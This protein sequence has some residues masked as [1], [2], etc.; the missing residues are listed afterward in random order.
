MAGPDRPTVRSGRHPPERVVVIGRAGSGKTT[1]ALALGKLFHIPVVYLDQLYWTSDWQPVSNDRYE[2]LHAAA[3]AAD[4]WILDGGYMTRP[5]FTYRV[6]RADL[7][8]ITEASLARCLV[9]VV[10]R[11]LW[12]RGRPRAGRPVGAEEHFSLTFL[13]WIFRWT[14]KHR[15]LAAEIRAL[16]PAARIVVVRRAQDLE[17]LLTP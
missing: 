16:D 5:S 8:V 13:V 12:H 17:R 4:R 15:D 1:T 9:R 2:A 10:R 14:R 7:V 6:R 3:I 11:T